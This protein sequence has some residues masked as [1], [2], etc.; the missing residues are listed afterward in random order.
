MRSKAPL[1]LMEQMVMIL[2]FALAA[3]LCLRA[4]VLSDSLSKENTRQDDAVL[5]AQNAAEVY[6]A[7]RGDGTAAAEMLGGEVSQGVWSSFYTEDLTAAA[8][9]EN[10]AYMVAVLPEQ[11]DVPGLGRAVAAVF[12]AD[13]SESLFELDVAWQKEANSDG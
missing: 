8:N 9:R 4:F 13:G 5:L 10:A 2:V 3:A 11:T 12:E 6:K 7:C 1:A